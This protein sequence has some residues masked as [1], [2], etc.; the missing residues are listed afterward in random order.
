MILLSGYQH[1][2]YVERTHQTRDAGKQEHECQCGRREL[3][4]ETVKA[5]AILTRVALRAPVR[6]GEQQGEN[7]KLDHTLAP[8]VPQMRAPAA[9]APV[10]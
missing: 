8:R 3:P 1:E 6:P 4:P 10:L 9:L 5:D 7:Q 2:Q